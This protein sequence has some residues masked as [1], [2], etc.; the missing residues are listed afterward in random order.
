M[1]LSGAVLASG[2]GMSGLGS[3]A[4]TDRGDGAMSFEQSFPDR[5]R[6]YQ[7]CIVSGLR[8]AVRQHRDPRHSMRVSAQDARASLQ[9][10]LRAQDAVDL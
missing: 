4:V 6:W 9:L 7:R 10:A 1:R 3:M 5:D 2:E 8:D